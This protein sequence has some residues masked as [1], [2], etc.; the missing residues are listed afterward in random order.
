MAEDMNR[1]FSKEDIQMANRHMKRC[2]TSLIIRE[3][4]IKTTMRYH[5]TPVRMAKINNTRKTSVGKDAKKEEPS[6]TVGENA[7]WCSNSGEQYGGPSNN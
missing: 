5:F 3:T 7:N 4:Q 2:S 6:C 1:H